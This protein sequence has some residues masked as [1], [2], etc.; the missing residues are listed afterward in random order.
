MNKRLFIFVIIFLLCSSIYGYDLFEQVNGNI[1]NTLQDHVKFQLILG[2]Q[3]GTAYIANSMLGEYPELYDSLISHFDFYYLGSIDPNYLV[4]EVDRFYS[5]EENLSCPLW[6]A[7]S[8]AFY[9]LI[10]LPEVQVGK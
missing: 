10:Y 9:N 2:Y 8:K 4:S 6:R 7:V 3:M 5:Y 1:W